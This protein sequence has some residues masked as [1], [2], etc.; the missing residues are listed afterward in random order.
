[1]SPRFLQLHFLTAYPAA[2]LNR[3]DVGFAKRLTFGGTTRTRI[4]SQC[5]K[6]HW[7]TFEGEHGLHEL[8]VPDSIRSRHTFEQLIVR[9][10]LQEGVAPELARAVTEGLMNEVLGQSAKAKKAAAESKKARQEDSEEAG[11]KTR[12]GS[13]KKARKADAEEEA[14]MTGQ[15][16]VLG[17][18]EVDF[19]L[20]EARTLCA[21]VKSP[22]KAE[23]AIKARFTKERRENLRTLRHGA[24][25]SA[26]LFGRMVTSDI[27]SRGDAAVHVAHAFTVHE[28]SPESDYF[29]AVDGLK[30]DDADKLGSGH[31]GSTELTSGL[32]Y[33]YVVVDVPLLVS[34]LEGCERKAWL[35]ANRDTAA[36]LVEKLV[37]LVATV[38]PGAKLGSTAPYAY[39]HMVL[40]EAGNSQPRTLAN[41]FLQ[42][43]SQHGDVVANAYSDLGKYVK[44]VDDMYG[45]NTQRRLSALGNTDAL[46]QHLR[47]EAAMPLQHVAAWAA[48]QVREGQ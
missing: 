47:V 28:E 21:E 38:S 44:G 46:R 34:N 18:P 41:A 40:V 15:I 23:E 10:L 8:P 3:D 2:L 33:G 32:F 25:L 43:V 45:L 6:R 14:L 29:S 20:S 9:P 13:E 7:R 16:T 48:S 17:R 1:M 11:T 42:A 22:D 27:L 37:H 4:S 12:K 36:A 35:Q 5:L 31:I 26:A 30:T 24:G 19:L 39:A